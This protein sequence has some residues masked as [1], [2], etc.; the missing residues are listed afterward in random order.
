MNGTG[1]RARDLWVENKWHE[2]NKVEILIFA[3]SNTYY[4]EIQIDWAC[5]L[6]K[7]NYLVKQVK[8]GSSWW[9]ERVRAHAYYSGDNDF[10]KKEQKLISRAETNWSDEQKKEKQ[11]PYFGRW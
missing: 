10:L 8:C 3:L 7:Y 1:S 11:V 2:Y 4:C 9:T 6:K 5:M